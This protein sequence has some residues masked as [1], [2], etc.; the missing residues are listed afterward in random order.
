MGTFLTTRKM[1]PAL[2]RRI[3]RSV[4]AGT[5]AAHERGG[6]RMATAIARVGAAIA[7]IGLV[8]AFASSRSHAK[9]EVERSRA[10]LLDAARAARSA[11]GPAQTGFM[12]RVEP[13]LVAL[14]G[15]YEGDVVAGE[16]RA[17]RA[18]DAAL[19]RP[20]VYVRGPAASLTDAAGIAKAAASSTKD[21]PLLCLLDPPASRAENVVLARVRAAYAGTSTTRTAHA[22][23]LD[24]VAAGVRAWSAPWEA[25]AHDARDAREIAD[26]RAALARVPVDDVKRAAAAELLIAAVDEPGEEGPAELDGER[27]HQVRVAIVDVNARRVLVRLRRRVD[28]SALGA[29]TRAAYAGA[30]DGCAL[31]VDVRAAVT[32]PAPRAPR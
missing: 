19:A 10:E 16:L 12:A 26:V 31:A 7:L 29:S 14:A 32:E 13:W 30:W 6:R 2:A 15:P 3:E 9:R 1:A 23:R 22:R 4:G 20:S 28:P 18:L 21:A 17:P 11:L 24:E 27:A 25:R 5:G 8:S